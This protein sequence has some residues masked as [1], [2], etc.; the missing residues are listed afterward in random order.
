MALPVLAQIYCLCA[1]IGCLTVLVSAMTGAMHHGAGAHGHGHTG[2][3]G[4]HGHTGAG[5]GHQGPGKIGHAHGGAH[6]HAHGAQH[7]HAH[8]AQAHGNDGG[9]DQRAST[10]IVRVN[11]NHVAVKEDAPG[12]GIVLLTWLNPNTIAA[13]ATWFGAIGIMLWRLAPIPLL[14]TLPLAILGGAFGAKLMMTM[15]AMI[16]NRMYQSGTFSEQDIIGIAAEVTVPVSGQGLGEII[17][18]VGGA[19]HTTSARANKPEQSLARGAKAIICDIRD[20]IAYIEPW[21]E[22]FALSAEEK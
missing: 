4:G 21:T 9:T 18:S 15:V 6:G 22:E 12:L 20:D 13:F 19:R 11:R 5:H 14:F 2:H 16:G 1:G 17:Y 8:G 7:G 10:G 3:I